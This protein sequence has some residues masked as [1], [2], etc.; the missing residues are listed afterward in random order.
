MKLLTSLAEYVCWRL[1]FNLSITF[2]GLVRS[3][4]IINSFI[5]CH[6]ASSRVLPVVA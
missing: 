6:N 3:N 5:L 2:N 1:F 4:C